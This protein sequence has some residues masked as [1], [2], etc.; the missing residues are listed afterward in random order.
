[1]KIM[2][3]KKLILLFIAIVFT[4]S[5]WAQEMINPKEDFLYDGKYFGAYPPYLTFG[6]GHGLNTTTM[7]NEQNLSVDF[8]M[9]IKK[10]DYAFNLGYFASTPRFLEGDGGLEAFFSRQKMHDFHGGVGYRYERLKNNFGVYGG[11]SFV[12]GRTPVDTLVSSNAFVYRRTP[13]L[14][15]QANY[16]RKPHYDVGYGITLYAVYSRYYKIIGLQAH[17]FLSSAFK[18]Y[19]R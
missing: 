1:M 12:A 10:T 8:H 13:G 3:L 17:I 16:S 6:L 4:H 5:L 14:Y 15:I 11:A 9:Q 18:S 7:K 19:T 2:L